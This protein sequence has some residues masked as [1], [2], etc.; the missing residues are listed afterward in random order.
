[1]SKYKVGDTLYKKGAFEVRL[2]ESDLDGSFAYYIINTQTNVVEHTA[3][4]LYECMKLAHIFDTGI[5]ELADPKA[6]SKEVSPLE[7][8]MFNF[9]DK[10]N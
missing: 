4:V 1:M 2:S 9:P 5:T 8:M 7:Q 3:K 6:W 10:A